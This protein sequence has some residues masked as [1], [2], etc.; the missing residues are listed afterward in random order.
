V[1]S[2]AFAP[3]LPEL[4]RR[5]KQRFQAQAVIRDNSPLRAW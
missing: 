3:F 5:A 4:A 2:N 1:I